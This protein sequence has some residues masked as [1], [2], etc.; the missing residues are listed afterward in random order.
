MQNN[1]SGGE[2]E[3]R[4]GGLALRKLLTTVVLTMT[5]PSIMALGWLIGIRE[6]NI[7]DRNAIRN[8]DTVTVSK[9]K[10]IAVY[11]ADLLAVTETIAADLASTGSV[12]TSTYFPEATKLSVIALDDMGTVDLAPGVQGLSSHIGVDLV[13]RAFAGEQPPP[14]VVLNAESQHVL[15]ARS[16]GEPPAGVVLAELSYQRISHLVDSGDAEGSYQLLQ[17]LSRGAEQVIAG[18]LSGQI[19]LA[20]A[21]IEGTSW[22]I[23]FAP[24]PTWLAA[25]QP[26]WSGAI[27]VLL[28][29]FAGLVAGLA[30]LIIGLQQL[31]TREAEALL[32]LNGNYRG[33][34][35][36][37]LRAFI[38][39]AKMLRQLSQKSRRQVVN[40]GRNNADT[41]IAESSADD[42]D[43]NDE[44]PVQ[45]SDQPASS[46]ESAVANDGAPHPDDGLQALFNEDCIQGLAAEELTDA[47][48]GKMASAIAV[49]A[50]DRNIQTFVVAYD[51]RPSSARIRTTVVKALLASGKDVIDL[52]E[53]PPAIVHYAMQ[54]G[55]TQSSI[56]ISS[57]HPDQ[58][59]NGLQ[60]TL[61][62]NALRG[63]DLQEVLQV[64]RSEQRV[65]GAGR[66]AKE[67]VIPAYLDQIALDVMLALPLK[68]VIDCDY[69]SA[70]HIAPDLIEAL[71]CE[72]Q[73]L[74]HP[75][76]AERPADWQLHSA[77]EQL[78][79]KVRAT[80]ADI[81]V[82]LDSNGDQLHT[83]TEKGR[84]VDND[85]VMMLLARDIL[86]RN[87]G[88]NIVYDVKFTR[89]FGPFVNQEGG[90]ALLAPSNISLIRDKMR[91]TDAPFG[92][93]FNGRIIFRDRWYD[94]DDALYGIAR[95][96]EVVA[97]ASSSYDDMIAELPQSVSTPEISLAVDDVTRRKLLRELTAQTDFPGARVTTMDGL[98]LDYADSWGVVVNGSCGSSLSMRF[99]GSD[100]KSLTRVQTIFRDIIQKAAPHVV[101]PF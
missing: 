64:M 6:P 51:A 7:H 29:M 80:N 18:D 85:L 16:F 43:A 44:V 72:I 63:N 19:P 15:L 79:Q 97:T 12:Q 13:R 65:Q 96:L 93:D 57:N 23:E 75:D 94:F 99:E 50:H 27:I 81:G 55:S 68:V 5:I 101:L 4:A 52:G 60:I 86:E 54:K 58:A 78:G 83:V 32:E 77:L 28:M 73:T 38:P 76:D 30:V 10:L 92:G 46:T 67:N 33:G 37:N 69:G 56:M 49:V 20:T 84:A 100:A 14:E 91:Q 59:V 36:L 89:H 47:V 82:L 98:R 88:A 95:L 66:T 34:M 3:V 26:A 87:P 11:L 24:K 62:N 41:M 2:F 9:A 17:R 35:K 1:T 39:V 48:V 42:V 45:P 22:R 21:P 8:A 25:V 61:D 53:V 90:R 70:A 71:D 74:N 31:L 40:R